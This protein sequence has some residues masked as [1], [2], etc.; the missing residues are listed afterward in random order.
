MKN[1]Y[2]LSNVYEIICKS[3]LELKEEIINHGEEAWPITRNMIWSFLLNFKN[4][5]IVE[6]KKTKFIFKNYGLDSKKFK[7]IL[8]YFF[9][10]FIYKISKKQF[11][12]KSKFVFF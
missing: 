4:K 5:I 10:N 11:I 7:R 3:E 6:E 12:K 1:K 2:T 8:I 9:R